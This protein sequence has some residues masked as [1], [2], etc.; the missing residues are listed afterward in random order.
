MRA[1]E[2]ILREYYD[3]SREDELNATEAR[4]ISDEQVV[5]PK[6]VP[7]SELHHEIKRILS[8]KW[9]NT[10]GDLKRIE[11]IK[12]AIKSTNKLYPIWV[13]VPDESLDL[14][15][16]GS[17]LEEGYHRLIAWH[18]LGIKQVPVMFMVGS[19]GQVTNESTEQ[20]PVN[21]FI[22]KIYSEYP[23]SPFNP[24]QRGIVSGEGEDQ[25]IALFELTPS[26]SVR[27][28]V[29]LHWIQAYPQRKGVGTAAI[30]ELQTKAREAGLK[31]TLYPQPNGPVSQASLKRLYK[32][33]GFQPI[34]KGG[35]TMV[36][37]PE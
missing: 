34:Q 25:T 22:D 3:P 23:Q 5:G 33:L 14:S 16:P 36:W 11:E 30:R 7:I 8:E 17:R 26:K 12:S 31:M 6:T 19:L 18:Q 35:S 13:Y 9:R 21:A 28:A 4:G 1:R 27:G 2:F 37:S 29:E 20:D 10:P 24:N 15:D 32:R